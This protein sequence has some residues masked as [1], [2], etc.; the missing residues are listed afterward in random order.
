[1]YVGMSSNVSARLSSHRSARGTNFSMR[2]MRAELGVARVV[3]E[4]LIRA[5]TPPW[6]KMMT[7][8][9]KEVSTDKSV[10]VEIRRPG[11]TPTNQ[12]NRPGQIGGHPVLPGFVLI[13]E[14]W[15]AVRPFFPSEQSARWFLRTNRAQVIEKKALAYAGGRL[16][17][18]A[19]RAAEV[20][21]QVAILRAESRL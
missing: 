9:R 20:I 10:V 4:H 21:E 12:G 6:N 16:W 17:I 5:F 11:T 3:E 19:E 14:L 8:K 13:N 15:T 2:Y 7:N 18:N 1:M